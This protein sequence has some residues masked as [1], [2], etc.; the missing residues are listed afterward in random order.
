MQY[1]RIIF[2]DYN[3]SVKF[4]GSRGDYFTTNDSMVIK[5]AHA[6]LHM[7]T[8]IMYKF[9]SSTC[10]TLGEKLQT[11]LCPRTDERTDRRTDSHSDSSIPLHFVVWGI[12]TSL[13]IKE[14]CQICGM[15]IKTMQAIQFD[16]NIFI[17]SRTSP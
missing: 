17:L 9:Q 6:Q 1:C 8:N 4:T 7:Y 3:N 13:V 11:K 16:Q 12:K 15:M 14:I 10:K 5:I 2:L